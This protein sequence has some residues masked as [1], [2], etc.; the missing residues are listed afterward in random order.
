MRLVPES[1][2]STAISDQEI[3]P[4]PTLAERIDFAWS[5]LRRR[6]LIVLGCLLFAL[7]VGGLYL[8]VTPAAYTASTTM[9]IDTRSNR[10]LQQ[11]ILGDTT[12]DAGWIESQIGV[13]R[14]QSV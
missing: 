8:Y 11:T 7:P 5:F 12:P 13:L 10:A 3:A 4:S 14:S 2:Q 9:L 6:Y 1:L